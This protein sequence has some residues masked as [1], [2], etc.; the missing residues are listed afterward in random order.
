MKIA[1]II[2]IVLSVIF[3]FIILYLSAID[4]KNKAEEASCE[5]VKKEFLNHTEIR[6][7]P[8]FTAFFISPIAGC[9]FTFLICTIF[10]IEI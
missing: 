8:F 1:W 9:V 7:F 6:N 4:I 5:E 2:W 10:N 3:F